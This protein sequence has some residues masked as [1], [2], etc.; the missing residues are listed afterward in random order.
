MERTESCPYISSLGYSQEHG[1]PLD[2]ATSSAIVESSDGRHPVG[3]LRE[4][5]RLLSIGRLPM[6]IPRSFYQIFATDSAG[7][8]KVTHMYVIVAQYLDLIDR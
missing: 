4:P 8:F 5:S 7:S 2:V 1:K 6:D 3:G